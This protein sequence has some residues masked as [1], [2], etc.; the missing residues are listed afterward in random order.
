MKKKKSRNEHEHCKNIRLVRGGSVLKCKLEDPVYLKHQQE[1]LKILHMQHTLFL[2]RII[3]YY[4]SV[5]THMSNYVNMKYKL[6]STI[7][8]ISVGFIPVVFVQSNQR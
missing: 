6:I 2:F 5:D 4:L 3:V 1:L 7:T 8:V